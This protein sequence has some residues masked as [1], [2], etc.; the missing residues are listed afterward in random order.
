MCGE[1]AREREDNCSLNLIRNQIF[2][3]LALLW[4][5]VTHITGVAGVARVCTSEDLEN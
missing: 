5:T 3:D 4:I 2:H 1:L